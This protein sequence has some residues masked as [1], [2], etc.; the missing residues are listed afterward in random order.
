MTTIRARGGPHRLTLPW[1]SASPGSAARSSL[2][3]RTLFTSPPCSRPI[4]TARN[5]NRLH[6]GYKRCLHFTLHFSNHHAFGP[7]SAAE[8]PVVYPGHGLANVLP[9][10]TLVNQP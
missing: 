8:D 4:R 9:L 3:S 7:C 2:R 1:P 5:R 6:A 10:E